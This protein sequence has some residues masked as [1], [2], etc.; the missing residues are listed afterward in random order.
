MPLKPH[1][2]MREVPLD[3]C[4]DWIYESV[5][6]FFECI[7]P[8]V[9]SGIF[10]NATSEHRQYKQETMPLLALFRNY[11]KNTRIYIGN[12]RTQTRTS[13][14]FTERLESTSPRMQSTKWIISTPYGQMCP[15]RTDHVSHP[16][17]CDHNRPRESHFRLAV[18]W[19]R[20][21]STLPPN[22]VESG[23]AALYLY[24]KLSSFENSQCFSNCSRYS[25]LKDSLP[26][27]LRISL[28][29]YL[30]GSNDVNYSIYIIKE[31]LIFVG[32]SIVHCKP[33]LRIFSLLEGPMYISVYKSIYKNLKWLIWKVIPLSHK[34]SSWLDGHIAQ[35]KRLYPFNNQVSYGRHSA[36]KVWHILIAL[37]LIR[38]TYLIPRNRSAKTALKWES[39]HQGH[40]ES[41]NFL[42]HK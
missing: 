40:R 21:L 26:S 39:I 6:N 42:V 19:F 1:Q 38:S 8:Q 37:L 24:H 4:T 36:I 28:S 31:L 27:K 17:E 9:M 23:A 41:A 20:I 16:Y 13:I 7:K 5:G 14:C 25:F 30:S 18:T 32:N 12:I 15:Y 35:Q 22:N 2:A 10:V 29:P 33:R 3:M 34:L 11:V